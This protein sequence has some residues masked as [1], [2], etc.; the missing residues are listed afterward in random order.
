MSRQSK[1]QTTESQLADVVQSLTEEILVMRMAIDDLTEEIQWANQNRR[2][3]R[4]MTGR[5]IHSCSLD[6]TSKDFTVNSVDRETVD[7][8]RAELTS[9]QDG[10]EQREL[11]N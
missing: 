11:F 9:P 2:E 7:R 5:R 3:S 8:L 6:P 4:F 10:G 1:Q